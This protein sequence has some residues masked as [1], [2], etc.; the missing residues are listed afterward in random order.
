MKHMQAGQRW[1]CYTKIEFLDWIEYTVCLI[2]KLLLLLI[3]LLALKGGPAFYK[4]FLRETKK[5]T[6]TT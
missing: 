2:K 3:Y 4:V 1:V 6:K 5:C